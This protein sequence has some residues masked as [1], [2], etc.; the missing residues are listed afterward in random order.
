[1]SRSSAKSSR[2]SAASAVAMG[3]APSAEPPAADTPGSGP[4]LGKLE[5]AVTQLRQQAI[6]PMLRR[7]VAALREED[8]LTGARWA[9]KALN[10]D[11][12]AGMAW[13]VLAVA[14]EKAGDFVQSI[15]AYQSALALLPDESD[16]AN[17]LGRLA[18]RMGMKDLAE[19]LFRRYLSS[20][21]TSWGTVCSLAT[22]VRDQGR[23]G[24]AIEIL[25]DAIRQCP[26]EADLWNALGAVMAEKADFANAIIFYDE[27]L[28]LSPDTVYAYYNR[29]NAKLETGDTAGALADCE[30]AFS[31][32]RSP[33]DQMMMKLARSTIKIAL[34]RI[35]EGWD[36]YE[37]RLSPHFADSTVFVVNPPQWDLDAPIDGKSLLVMAEQGLGDEVLFANMLPDLIAALGPS[38]K[39]AMSVE[40]R[41]VSLF[42]RSFPGA[43]FVPHITH[44]RAGRNYRSAP[45]LGDQKQ[46]DLWVPLATPLRKF[47]RQLEDF[48]V[49]ERFLTAD[50]ERVAYWRHTL[51][52]APAG[53]KV[54]I[55]WKSM[56]L[57]SARA[58]YYSAFE[59]WAPVLKTPGVTFVNVQYGD[60]A[61][62]I[63]WARRELGVE[64]WSPPGIDLKNDLDDVA[65]LSV[66]LDLTIG[67]MN[68]TSNIAA[69]CG[70]PTWMI[71]VPGAWTK[72]GTEHMPWYPQARV[73]TPK[74]VGEWEDTMG[75]VAEA[76]AEPGGTS[77]GLEG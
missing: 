20:H 12:R 26:T 56:K 45:D 2:K 43:E 33:S 58:R 8:A 48:P 34:G 65:A 30:T 40:P 61:A 41:L 14:R 29:G 46:F 42:Q 64:I 76:L 25:R 4:A 70:A 50:P 23:G 77:P 67:F 19:Q 11:P 10:L 24:E 57:D 74:V 55:L 16:V 59:L 68:A 17:D 1:M 27:A 18:F 44:R 28:R 71:S 9:L 32:A 15:K 66:A 39:L 60:C 52:S 54:G 37:A 5:T 72:L 3:F 73:F 13:Y 38:G 35:A 51:E 62:E 49:R 69:A 47:R 31:R 63:E 75:A 6:T 21:P 22:A 53:R 36:D 7:A